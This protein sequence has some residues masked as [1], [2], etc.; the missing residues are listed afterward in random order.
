MAALSISIAG[1]LL[2]TGPLAIKLLLTLVVTV[3]LLGVFIVSELGQKH[4]KRAFQ[5]VFFFTVLALSIIGPIVVGL[6]N[7]EGQI[8]SFLTFGDN[9]EA[10]AI[11]TLVD[12]REK[13]LFNEIGVD[14]LI[15]YYR[16]DTYVEAEWNWTLD[17][18]IP[19]KHYLKTLGEATTF[20]YAWEDE[21]DLRQYVF[22][23]GIDYLVI[24]ESLIPEVHFSSQERITYLRAEPWL[25]QI[26]EVELKNKN[27]Y[28]FQVIR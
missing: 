13:T 18:S 4:V 25:E 8:Y 27:A 14:Y 21:E 23:H 15:Q 16:E 12:S 11:A 24:T 2:S 6:N 26:R 1:D 9:R 28:V 7:Q 17:E 3:L 5:A 10:E 19:K 20:E 22:A